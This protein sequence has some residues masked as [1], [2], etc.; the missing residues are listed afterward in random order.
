MT[1]AS[2]EASAAVDETHVADD[3]ELKV[4]VTEDTAGGAETFY[5]AMTANGEADDGVSGSTALVVRVDGESKVDV[6]LSGS[7]DTG[8]DAHD[9]RMRMAGASQRITRSPSSRPSARRHG[10][11]TAA[12]P[13][14]RLP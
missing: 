11:P 9:A 7:V 14:S 4:V 8:G 6:E 10:L 3:V 5:A 13:P 1:E 12:H 2:S